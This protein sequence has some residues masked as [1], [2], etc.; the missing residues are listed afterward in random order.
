[1]FGVGVVFA[2][3]LV[4]NL[5]PIQG[6]VPPQGLSFNCATMRPDKEKVPGRPEVLPS[7][8]KIDVVKISSYEPKDVI[9]VNLTAVPGRRLGA[10]AIQAR[11]LD[12]TAN[13]DEPIG[14]WNS[15]PDEITERNCRFAGNIFGS[16]LV[17]LPSTFPRDGVSLQWTAPDRSQGHLE[18]LA[19]FVDEDGSTFWLRERSGMIRDPLAPPLPYGLPPPRRPPP[20]APINTAECGEKKG[21]Y[22]EP[23][24]CWEPYCDYLVTWRESGSVVVFEMSTRHDG[25]DDRWLA[26][27]LSED[28]RMG[29]D[30]VMEC[31]HDS[32]TG[33]VEVFLSYNEGKHNER[34]TNRN[35]DIPFQ[36]GSYYNG[37]LRCRF[38]RRIYS[39][40]RDGDSR[41]VPLMSNDWHILMARGHAHEGKIFRHGL[42]VNTFPI[43]SPRKVSLRS[44]DNF[45]GR[46]KFPLVKAHACLMIFAFMFC[47]TIAL[48]MVKYYK[49]MW[50][51]DRFYGDRYWLV[52]HRSLMSALFIAV[53]IAF[54]LIFIEA[55]GYS[56]AP[57]L[58]QKAHPILGIIIFVCVVINPIL[59][60]LRPSD[61][62]KWRP[63]FN[64]FHWAFGTIAN[65]LA[66]PNIFIGMDF[67][68]PNVPWWATWILLFYVIF[69]LIVEVTLEVHQC[70]TYKKNKERRRKWQYA[71]KE[72]PKVY[73]PEPDPVG[74]RFKKNML[75]THVVVTTI[76]VLVMIIIVAVC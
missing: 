2:M 65:V 54:I 57:D 49:F 11:R 16:G 63:V 26:V 32:K 59:A 34:L 67:G 24:W 15:F 9:Y 68:K 51:N 55:G 36:E 48:V 23:D 40:N 25:F 14:Y 43:S 47:A 1:M 31:V 37:M 72:N 52:V 38:S 50:P 13:T 10:F 7:P 30:S 29:S 64:W 69:H 35:W 27:G 75:I 39:S 18:F 28:I 20:I 56:Q 41:V 60:L 66:I 76:V 4:G 8:F 6:V 22:R 3:L 53:I 42:S 71:K 12:K 17:S 58:P 70:C 62:S 46:A 61:T 19:T 45:N 74:H 5:T 33:K 21:C 44:L 73:H